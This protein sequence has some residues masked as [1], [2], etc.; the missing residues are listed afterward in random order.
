MAESAAIAALGMALGF[1]FYGVVVVVASGIIRAQTGVV[2]NP[3]EPHAVMLHAPLGIIALA[4]L[5]G[6]FPALKAYRTDVA[7][8]IVPQS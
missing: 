1:V 8:N 6:V 3:F 4:A 7:E 5:C 2:I